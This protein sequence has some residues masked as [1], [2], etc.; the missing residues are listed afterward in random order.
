MNPINSFK[1]WLL[2]KLIPVIEKTDN[3]RA[4]VEEIINLEDRPNRKKESSEQYSDL[5][6]DTEYK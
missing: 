5:L 1:S 6:E 2:N 4:T 3:K